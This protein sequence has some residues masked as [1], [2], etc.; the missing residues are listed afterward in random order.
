MCKIE[1]IIFRAQEEIFRRMRSIPAETDQDGVPDIVDIDPQS[2][3][4]GYLKRD[5]GLVLS[6]SSGDPVP[7]DRA[8]RLLRK[9]LFFHPHS[10]AVS[11][12]FAYICAFCAWRSPI[13]AVINRQRIR[14]VR[15]VIV[16][17]DPVVFEYTVCG[18]RRSSS[19]DYT[20]LVVLNDHYVVDCVPYE[21]APRSP[22]MDFTAASIARVASVE[23]YLRRATHFKNTRVTT[24]YDIH[25]N[26]NTAFNLALRGIR[27]VLRDEDRIAG[28][29]VG[30]QQASEVTRASAIV[31]TCVSRVVRSARQ[32]RTAR[33][34]KSCGTTPTRHRI[35]RNRIR[36]PSGG[37][38]ICPRHGTSDACTCCV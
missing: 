2:P 26:M 32:G 25:N 12:V 36:G 13:L 34:R 28:R 29:I 11:C 21:D 5:A 3:L 16:Y 1:D 35:K 38:T 27:A 20:T 14:S 23:D 31:R 15:L 4:T 8:L 33:L 24:T 22:K 7:E 10:V 30:A 19:K 18:H 6:S 37:S 9:S 17:F